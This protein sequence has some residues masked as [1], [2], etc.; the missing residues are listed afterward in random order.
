MSEKLLLKEAAQK[1]GLS[2]WELRTGA[3]SG[4]YPVLRVGGKRGKFIFDIELLE[5]RIL[6][7]MTSGL[8]DMTEN[9]NNDDVL[10]IEKIR[11]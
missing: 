4:K 6:E 11:L 1:V 7:L 8:V 9:G 3:I 5:K 2:V 10:N